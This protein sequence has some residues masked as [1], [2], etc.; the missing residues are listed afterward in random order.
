[1]LHMCAKGLASICKILFFIN[2]TLQTASVKE[3]DRNFQ[4]LSQ[5]SGEVDPNRKRKIMAIGKY[6]N[7]FGV[8]R[9]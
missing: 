9:F 1:M 6:S 7:I 4:K 5:Y 3:V 8:D 2:V